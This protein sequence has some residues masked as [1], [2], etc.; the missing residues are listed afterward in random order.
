[1]S[2]C[3]FVFVFLIEVRDM[4]SSVTLH[5]S[6]FVFTFVFEVSIGVWRHYVS[7]CVPEEEERR[8]NARP[9]P[10]SL[11]GQASKAN[12]KRMYCFIFVNIL[13]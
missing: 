11:I 7:P 8:T 3:I 9:V 1:M 13:D 12:V 6:T 5:F 10:F 2:P 4:T